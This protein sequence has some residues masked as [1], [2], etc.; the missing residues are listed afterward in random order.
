MLR[1]RF[2]GIAKNNG[3]AFCFLV[4]TN[5]DDTNKP[6]QVIARTV[7]KRHYPQENPPVVDKTR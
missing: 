7:V 6:Q 1:G 3:D 2:L 5:P 4:L